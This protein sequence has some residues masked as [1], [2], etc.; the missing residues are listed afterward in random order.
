MNENFTGL[1]SDHYNFDEIAGSWNL[2]DC[3]E[4]LG[5]GRGQVEGW[6]GG[7]GRDWTSLGGAFY[8]DYDCPE[9]H[10]HGTGSV[11]K[12]EPSG[13]EMPTFPIS[14]YLATRVLMSSNSTPRSS[15]TGDLPL[16]L[17]LPLD[18]LAE[19]RSGTS[20]TRSSQVLENSISLDRVETSPPHLLPKLTEA[21]T[22]SNSARPTR[23]DKLV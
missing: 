8:V 3:L 12:P 6:S 5:R 23:Y 13:W 11:R 16:S 22:T 9:S 14:D 10:I 1:E 7:R 17:A 21:K 18:G 4:E 2:D 19:Q 20:K 15:S